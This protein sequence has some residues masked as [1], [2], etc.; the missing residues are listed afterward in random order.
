MLIKTSG[1][2]PLIYYDIFEILS[3]PRGTELQCSV[4]LASVERSRPGLIIFGDRS[5]D[6]TKIFSEQRQI[7][8]R[9]SIPLVFIKN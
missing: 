3:P 6:R 2:D 9:G 8:Y 4:P 7:W 1:I 5:R